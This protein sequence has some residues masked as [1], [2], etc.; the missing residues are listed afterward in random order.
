MDR[1]EL[2]NLAEV[3]PASSDRTVTPVRYRVTVQEI[4]EEKWLKPEYQVIGEVLNETRADG[5][6]IDPPVPVNVYGYAWTTTAN[7][8]S[9]NIYEQV[10]DS[11]DLA[12]VVAAVNN[13]D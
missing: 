7:E 13:L 2:K 5:S 1:E 12:K 6:L 11:L 4:S 3:K 8:V 9:V 10:V